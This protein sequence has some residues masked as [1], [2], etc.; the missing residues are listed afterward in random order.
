MYSI[1]IWLDHYIKHDSICCLDESSANLAK[2]MYDT[3]QYV[4]SLTQ[5]CP[6]VKPV[7]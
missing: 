6:L 7:D 4:G 1:C 5:K 2:I 3:V